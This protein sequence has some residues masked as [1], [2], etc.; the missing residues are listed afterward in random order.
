MLRNTL[1]RHGP[2]DLFVEHPELDPLPLHTNR[3]EADTDTDR[4]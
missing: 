3:R 4:L 1:Q 2:E